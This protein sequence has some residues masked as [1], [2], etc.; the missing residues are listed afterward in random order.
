MSRST[1]L[2]FVIATMVGCEATAPTS[3]LEM[4][5]AAL[6]PTT[7]SGRD[8]ILDDPGIVHSEIEGPICAELPPGDGGDFRQIS[9]AGNYDLPSFA[10]DATVFLNGWSLEYLLEPEDDDVRG[11]SATIRDISFAGN[12][13]T[14]NAVGWIGDDDGENAYKFCYVYTVVAWASSTI[15]FSAEHLAGTVRFDGVDFEFYNGTT[16]DATTALTSISSE[17]GVPLF[18]RPPKPSKTVGVLPRG[19]RFEFQERDHHIRQ[20]AYSIDHGER[21]KDA[22]SAYDFRGPDSV[23]SSDLYEP[24]RV[25][26]ETYGILKDDA[27]RRDYLFFGQYTA[28]SGDDIYIVNPP[29]AILPVTDTCPSQTEPGIVREQRFAIE[30]IPFDYAI[31]MLSGWDLSYF[32]TNSHIARAGVWLKDVAYEKPQSGSSGTLRYTLATILADKDGEPSYESRHKVDVLGLNARRPAD[33]SPTPHGSN[34]GFCRRDDQG[35]LLVGISNLGSGI[36]QGSVTRVVF[37]SGAIVSLD[38][39]E[40]PGNFTGTLDPIALPAS[41]SGGCTFTVKADIADSVIELNEGNNSTE[42]RCPSF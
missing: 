39:P 5:Q 16:N 37:S 32:C 21:F 27:A 6:E 33:L 17:S 35:R 23:S 15:N 42:G 25:S 9:I 19:F 41:C 30:N 34:V 29:F 38:T 14:W 40:I 2:L 31:P 11:I 18:G 10:D 26:W 13:L 20:L 36:A 3:P 12:T 8:L 1:L 4:D 7:D 22:E 28:V 24:F